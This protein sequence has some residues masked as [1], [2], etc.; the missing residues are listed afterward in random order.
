ME[1]TQRHR[2]LIRGAPGH[3]PLDPVEGRVVYRV[4]DR[5]NR[6]NHGQQAERINERDAG[7]PDERRRDEDKPADL[8]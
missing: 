8:E 1:D 6:R 5:G 2:A 4:P 3:T 7:Q